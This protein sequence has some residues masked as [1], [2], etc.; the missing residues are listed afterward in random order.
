M[1]CQTSKES[2]AAANLRA[3]KKNE[4]RGKDRMGHDKGI[5]GVTP[6][7]PEDVILQRYANKA[8]SNGFLMSGAGGA[9]AGAF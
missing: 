1:G 7:S 3:M 8:G 6:G 5:P 4:A 2:V 9:C